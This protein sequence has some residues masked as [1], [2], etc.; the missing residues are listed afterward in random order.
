MPNGRSK[1][2]A[3]R[4]TMM[5]IL[6]SAVSLLLACAGFFAYD[7]VS[8]R[9]SLVR[10]LSAQAQIIASNSVAALLFNDPQ[11]ASVTLSALESSQNIVSAAIFTGDQRLFVQYVKG[12]GD[13]ILRVPGF[14]AKNIEAHWFGRAHLTL[15]RRIVSNGKPIGFVYLRASLVEIDQ[16]L[17]RYALI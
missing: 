15:V 6:V 11:S 7:Q 13:E 12:Q 8:V 4:L 14:P 1:S 9:E 16:R 2:I 17:K 5:N 3:K 10:T